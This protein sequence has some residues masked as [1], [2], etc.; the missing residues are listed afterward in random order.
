MKLNCARDRPLQLLVFNEE[1]LVSVSHQLVSTTFL[2]FVYT[3][4]RYH[5]L[6]GL[7]SEIFG[8]EC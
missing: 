7:A 1:F 5:K 3:A 8:L 4:R 2:P 6:N